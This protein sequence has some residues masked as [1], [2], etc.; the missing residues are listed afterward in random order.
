MARWKVTAKHYLY[1]EQW[2]QPTEWERQETN[3]ATGRLFRKAYKVPLFID[4]DDPFCQNKLE[5]GLCIVARQESARPGDIVFFGPPTPDMEPMDD[6]ARAET[7]AEK[8]K[9]VNPIDSLAPEIGQEFGQQL[10]AAL[11][12]KVNEAQ[13][14]VS[15]KNV[16]NSD[17]EEL[18]AIVA[19]QQEMINKLMSQP[20]VEPVTLPTDAEQVVDNEPPLP[21]IEPTE[22]EKLRASIAASAGEALSQARAKSH[23]ERRQI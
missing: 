4:P 18:K 9:W 22:E 16:P 17:I 3:Q 14:P 20:K 15:L 5:G 19:K 21:D 13:A 11:Q 2:G 6:E 10:L 12:S 23:L 8:H 7:N 1:A